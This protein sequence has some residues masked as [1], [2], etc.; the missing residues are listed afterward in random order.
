MERTKEDIMNDI[1]E[2]QDIMNGYMYD[3]Q[4]ATNEQER[5]EASREYQKHQS[6]LMNLYEELNS[7]GD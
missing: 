2:T 6:A 5:I 4:N 7:V 3:M 1:Y